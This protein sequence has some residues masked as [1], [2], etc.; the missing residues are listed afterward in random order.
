MECYD[1]AAELSAAFVL[2]VVTLLKGERLIGPRAI[3]SF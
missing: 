3:P 1:K 2:F